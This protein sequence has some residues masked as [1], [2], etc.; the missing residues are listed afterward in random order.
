MIQPTI[1]KSHSGIIS[2][3]GDDELQILVSGGS[4]GDG[5]RA[6]MGTEVYNARNKR[7]DNKTYIYTAEIC[8]FRILNMNSG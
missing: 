8:R 6:M 3:L 4:R 7:Y 1:I 2:G 5:A